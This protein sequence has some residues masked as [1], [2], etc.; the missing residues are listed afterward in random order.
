M[1]SSGSQLL[2]LERQ[3]AGAGEQ[4]PGGLPGT[5]PTARLGARGAVQRG[6]PLRSQ[7]SLKLVRTT[8]S[9]LQAN[10]H[11]KPQVPAGHEEIQQSTLGG[12]QTP[13]KGEAAKGIPRA[14]PGAREGREGR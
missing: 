4:R 9:N 2:C 7:K 14:W 12:K 6:S 1:F 11:L 3:G 10:C 13:T 5:A 8:A